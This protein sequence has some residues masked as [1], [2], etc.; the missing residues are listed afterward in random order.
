MKF[1]I[2]VGSDAI[3]NLNQATSEAAQAYQSMDGNRLPPVAPM[4][5]V[6]TQSGG[7]SPIDAK[8]L[9]DPTAQEAAAGTPDSP[10]VPTTH[11]QAPV[12]DPTPAQA[13]VKPGLFDQGWKETGNAIMRG[14]AQLG[15]MAM[16]IGG[17]P[18]AVK[19]DQVHEMISGKPETGAQDAVFGVIDK[20]ANKLVDYFQTS[21]PEKSGIGAQVL[22]DVAS[23]VPALGLGLVA[24]EAVIP[25]L[26][27]QAGVDSMMDSAKQGLNAKTA[28]ILATT[29]SLAALAGA[30]MVPNSAKLWK[31]LAGSMGG[32]LL[33]SE[34]TAQLAKWTYEWGG[35]QQ[36][37]DK[38]DLSDPRTIASALATGILFALH[39]QKGPVPAVD[40]N[41][42]APAGETSPP[43]SP[44]G[45]APPPSGDEAD[46]NAMQ[47]GAGP[48]PP[49]PPGAPQSAA[50]DA[51]AVATPPSGAPPLTPAG[52][53]SAISTGVPGASST[54]PLPE[55]LKVPDTPGVE[56]ARMV[57]HQVLDMTKSTTPRNGVF[58]SND[59]LKHIN[60]TPDDA[61]GQSALGTMIQARDQGRTITLPNGVL[62]LKNK[63]IAKNTQLQLDKGVD[64][65]QVI[66]QVTV[67]GMGKTADQTAVV[68]GKDEAG[69]TAVEKMVRPDEV[70][71]ATAAMTDE[72]K[73]PVVTTPDA[74]IQERIHDVSRERNT[75]TEMGIVTTDNGKQIPVHVEPGA[76]EG[77][78]RVRL[79]NEDGEPS[80]TTKDIPSARVKVGAP[81]EPKPTPVAATPKQA[82]RDEGAPSPSAQDKPAPEVTQ[83][84]ATPT[85][86]KSPPAPVAK[87]DSNGDAVPSE[88]AQRFKNSVVKT[89][90]GKP[91]VLMHGTAP[92]S[93]S[94]FSENGSHFDSFDASK[95]GDFTKAP[96]AGMGFFFTD[97]DKNAAHYAGGGGM[98]NLASIVADR[99]SY[100]QQLE[101]LGPDTLD[102]AKH[103]FLTRALADREATIVAARNRGAIKD[104]Y[105]NLINPLVHDYQGAPYRE[106]TF[107][108]LLTKAKADGHDGA[109]FKNVD[110]PHR[111]NVYVAF[112]KDQIH[113]KKS[114]A[115]KAEAEPTPKV[116]V[117]AK[118]KLDEVKEKAGA[119][120]N[121]KPKITPEHQADLDA[122]AKV[123]NNELS[124]DDEVKDA[125]ARLRDIVGIDHMP[126]LKSIW[127][128]SR[129]ED[130]N[131]AP[132]LRASAEEA[133]RQKY[134]TQSKPETEVAEPK[135]PAYSVPTKAGP[136]EK[137]VAVIL[138]DEKNPEVRAD[139]LSALL[140][141]DWQHL[142]RDPVIAARA[143]DKIEAENA[144]SPK[145][146]LKA[147][148]PE[149][150]RDVLQKALDLH[151]TQETVGEKG[152]E[153]GNSDRKNI[154]NLKTRRDNMTTFAQGLAAAVKGFKPGEASISDLERAAKAAKLVGGSAD[155]KG[156]TKQGM[157]TLSDEQTAKNR[158]IGHSEISVINEE[159]HRVA[160]LLL[161]QGKPG[162][163]VSL[164]S[165]K[166]NDN[167]KQ[168]VAKLKRAAK[169]E[170]DD[171]TQ[172][173]APE[174]DP[175]KLAPTDA[176]KK[177]VKN[178]QLKAKA[179]AKKAKA[180]ADAKLVKLNLN[181]L[182]GETV[183]RTSQKAEVK[184]A[185][186][187]EQKKSKF[188]ADNFI[189]AENGADSEAAR[190][191]FEQHLWDTHPD[192]APE[193]RE[194]A[195]QLLD[196]R[197]ADENPDSVATGRMSDQI[198]DTGE[199]VLDPSAKLGA[200][201]SGT[202]IVGKTFLS[203]LATIKNKIFENK[204][205][206]QWERLGSRLHPD[207]VYGKMDSGQGV[208]S[209]AILDKL[210]AKADTPE[211]K[212][213]LELL[214][215]NMPDAPVYFVKQIRDL[216]SSEMLP[217]AG[218]LYDSDRN[219]IQVARG[220]TAADTLQDTIHEMFHAATVHEINSN[221]TGKL[222]NDLRHSLDVLRARMV[223][224]HGADTIREHQRYFDQQTSNAPRKW[225]RTLY[226]LTNIQEMLTEIHSNPDFQKE[227]AES[228]N[229]IPDNEGE[230]SH[231]G[232][233]GDNDSLIGRI[234]G[235]I[236]RFF[237]I[238][239]PKLLRHITGLG[240]MTVERQ[241]S[242]IEDY[243]GH[244]A[245]SSDWYHKNIVTEL[246]R[247]F[248]ANILDANRAAPGMAKLSEPLK[249]N[250]KIAAV[251]G[252][253][254][255]GKLLSI[256]RNRPASPDDSPITKI[257]AMVNRATSKIT[258]HTGAEHVL[259]A[260]DMARTVVAHVKSVDQIIR[261]YR[262]DFGLGGD[263][264]N[265]M[266]RVEDAM[267]AT[268]KISREF[269]AIT[270]PVAEMWNKLP[271]DI[272]LRLSTL[273]QEST[274]WR[275]DPRKGFQDNSKDAQKGYDAQNRHAEFVKELNSLP[276][277]V[278]NNT[279][280]NGKPKVNWDAKQLYNDVVEANK[281][282]AKQVHKNHI[283][284]ALKVFDDPANPLNDAQKR[285]LYSARGADAVDKLVGKD[286]LVDLGASNDGLKEA[287]KVFAAQAEID[288]PFAHLGREGSY[289]TH[290]NPTGTGEFA[291]RAAAAKFENYVNNLSPGSKA[292]YALLG[293]K[294]TVE[295]KADYT[296]FHAT[297]EE[298]IQDARRLERESG[299]I[300]VGNVTRKEATESSAGIAHGVSAMIS[301]AESKI[302]KG[303]TDDSKAAQALVQILHSALQRAQAANNAYAGSKLARSGAAGVKPE[304]MRKNFSD[305][306][307]SASWHSAQMSTLF[308]KSSAISALESAAREQDSTRIS[309][310][311]TFRR[312]EAVDIL[313]KHMLDEASH[314]GQGFKA[315]QFAAKLG[316]AA[317]MASPSHAILWS[318]Q[319]FTTSM[320]VASARWGIKPTTVAFYHSM[321]AVV[322]PILRA[323][324]ANALKRG[325]NSHDI[326]N[327]VVEV[328]RN[329]PRWS[330]YVTGE[331]SPFQQLTDRGVLDHGYSDQ[332][333]ALANSD[334]KPV[335]MVMEF[336]RL[337]PNMADSFNRISTALAGLE[338]THG[339]VRK[340]AD[341]V[342]EVH[343]DY[344]AGNK[345]LAFKQMDRMMP[346]ANSITMFMTYRQSMAHLLYS[347]V[348]ATMLGSGA[349]VK[350]AVTSKAA[351]EG[352]AA[353][354]WEAAKTVAG[355]VA[356]Q[357]PW[358][359]VY[360]AVALEPLRLAVYAYHKLFDKEGEVYDLKNTVNKWVGEV[361]QSAG[362]SRQAGENIASGAIP[363]SWG[364]D[365]SSRMGL[366]DLFFRDM[367]D[368]FTNSADNWKSF[369]YNE[370]GTMT[371]FI[372]QHITDFTTHMQN[373]EPGKAIS[374]LVPIK[375]Y[376]D[377]AKAIELATEGRKNSLGSQVTP[378]SNWDAFVRAVG[379]QPADI[380]QAQ[381][382]SR[383]SMD[384]KN[385]VK[386]VR[387]SILK[388]LVSG[389]PNAQDRMERFN[390]LHPSERIKPG[391]IRGLAK[392]SQGISSGAPSRDAELNEMENF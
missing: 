42:V 54:V 231:Y 181:P 125:H 244:L 150:P 130:I 352:T 386:G 187:A 157:G 147:V 328:L 176:D 87:T 219:M 220:D 249:L 186:T 209:H 72:G 109:I 28:G 339:D 128:D 6:R 37:A 317:Y 189:W 261:G 1:G 3:P 23:I 193:D 17:A 57:V 161:D 2:D 131:A 79:L 129:D 313:G 190:V 238:Q 135:P 49:G 202:R 180:E 158:G 117:K 291:T 73:T 44:G 285:L 199:S 93:E 279:L 348:K 251:A 345:P 18:L 225:N 286:K 124:D 59:T 30:K 69:V 108:N 232:A 259:S 266:N 11:D 120:T 46:L 350:G 173:V 245:Q 382:H 296:A 143:R 133:L 293:G 337:L 335:S 287:L 264:H 16:V 343:A 275:L 88:V 273:L 392:F 160:R 196:A 169:K 330:Q 96:S 234:M 272:D 194:R 230:L 314:Y 97:S 363:R 316:G 38:I 185:A 144:E 268:T 380:A 67:G 371:S 336:V 197:R 365:M 288:G 349:L 229:F 256:G 155:T 114:G 325:G 52:P 58:I 68:Q 182:E 361:A 222:A 82:S 243:G 152:R 246:M 35:Y 27:G 21:E 171:T 211:L 299:G 306:A 253:A 84:P 119:K 71:A 40:P 376:Q 289:V 389:K 5:A 65:Q 121:A 204:M 250:P 122:V 252:E 254:P 163:E 278:D 265:P 41:A 153:A 355:M 7:R 91:L 360:G 103:G 20:Y 75:P 354:T 210:L 90:D 80:A 218:G 83:G 334:A 236:G 221:P 255:G 269:H 324:I 297:R 100:R 294:H 340:T 112:D 142:S 116:T 270:R 89:S 74:A 341:F 162:D 32:N 281:T 146:P 292:S 359:G 374:S 267:D 10:L 242:G 391:D 78:T 63:A 372:A 226:G 346:G 370:S 184:V 369:I 149:G 127:P 53:G 165:G 358:A 357:I 384:Y 366:A 50:P 367:P 134:A 212:G 217:H 237:N 107:A 154:S 174:T 183:A 192:M 276:K 342:R 290:G 305:Y 385:V 233:I 15:R 295:Y 170:D 331:N 70:P 140:G 223:K 271:K 36:A 98:G 302:T 12:P 201:G 208:S 248:G 282:I 141:S 318:T 206:K 207:D 320:P 257:A 381:E 364:V 104:V 159:M 179:A 362:L 51:N 329:H 303:G 333:M 4:P 92:T 102:K 148:R 31:R 123:T 311:T 175:D 390:K 213:M 304:E 64:P 214:R 101:H 156:R 24:P 258:D 13:Q 43:G 118:T 378:P 227:I 39:R 22:G 76:P 312:G 277:E 263:A 280:V 241:R 326:H 215:R 99:D 138:K 321:R 178:A 332:M 172:T 315:N 94:A 200:K 55:G 235:A 19:A 47:P 375:A 327:A 195:L 45:P 319:N 168:A 177:A 310:A 61:N 284:T 388:G 347:N 106:E 62:L 137:W 113:I 60:G 203:R 66:G 309:Q 95:N 25:A 356:G 240:E 105:L 29:Q 377:G 56:S 283:D 81:D 308:E 48:G 260:I 387:S 301:K 188:L 126:S 26:V 132:E 34:G 344:S 274:R 111:G 322:S 191:K 167:I 307:Q 216:D 205:Q 86:P 298:A 353:K 115:K 139:K 85:E 166:N 373:G 8:P 379:F 262:G 145:A 368:L 77:F 224:R 247:R 239:D 110:D 300:N 9:R 351:A 323:G 198:K 14:T 228:E 136:H 383:V 151:E 164:M 33:V 338:L